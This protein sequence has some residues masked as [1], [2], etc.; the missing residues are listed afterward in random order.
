MLCGS[1]HASLPRQYAIAFVPVSFTQHAEE[2]A[3]GSSFAWFSNGRVIELYPNSKTGGGILACRTIL[4][5]FVDNNDV[6]EDDVFGDDVCDD[7]D[8]CD[9]DDVDV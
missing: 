4:D 2:I 8:V 1:C 7:F 6:F 9:D 5:D 3:V